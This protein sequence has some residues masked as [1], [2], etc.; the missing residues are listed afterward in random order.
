MRRRKVNVFVRGRRR[1]RRRRRRSRAGT[2][3]NP[4]RDDDG[5]HYNRR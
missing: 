1:L 4:T 5:D 2:Q 3:V